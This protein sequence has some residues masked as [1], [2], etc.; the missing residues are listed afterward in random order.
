MLADYQN[1][2][3]KEV[4]RQKGIIEIPYE[5]FSDEALLSL[6][7][8]FGKVVPGARGEVVQT[9]LAREKGKGPKGSFSYTVGYGQ[10]PW[11]TDTAYWDVPTRYLLLTSDKPSPC[12]TTYQSFDALRNAIKDFDY[13]MARSVYLVNVHGN[14]RY[15]SPSFKKAGKN[16]YRLDFHIF[17]PMNDEAKILMQ[18]VGY[19]L[20]K[21]YFRYL[22]TGKSVAVIDNWRIIHGRE[23]ASE[24]RNRILKRVYIDELV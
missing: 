1:K 5:N 23:S 12:A 16:G 24:D 14:R 10:F 9:L 3:Y 7:S 22:W 6:A 20:E 8:T 21:S 4:L 19:E 11:H 13:L 17:R 15:L 18:L 2:E